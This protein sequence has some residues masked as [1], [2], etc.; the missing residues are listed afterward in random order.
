MQR[1]TENESPR[2][3]TPAEFSV[4]AYF[5][6]LNRTIPQLPYASIQQ[7]ISVIMQA[8]E[9][10]RTVFVFGNG[11]SAA[12][13]SHVMCDLSKGT[14]GGDHA[15][16]L[17]V[18]ALTDNIPLLT[19]WANDA[20]YEHVFSQQI[21]NLVR[22]ADVVF[23]ISGSGNSPSIIEALKTAHD[24]GATVVGMAGFQGGKMRSLCDVCA[25]VPSDNIQ[26]VEDLHHA[27]AHSI[28]MAVRQMLC[29]RSGKAIANASGASTD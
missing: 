6:T 12:T 2:L 5:Q 3:S 23:A 18:I 10:D 9:E 7:I 29:S 13:A 27:I 1:G 26:V 24:L 11:G 28:L 15:P 22:P 19:A 4:Q 8:F 16:R 20:G 14:I 25:V 21:R 17:R